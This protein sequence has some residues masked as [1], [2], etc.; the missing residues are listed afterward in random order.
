MRKVR[1]GRVENRDEAGVCRKVRFETRAKARKKLRGP[2]VGQSSV[3][4]VYFCRQCL[5]WHLSS[6]RWDEPAK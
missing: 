2:V 1:G 6:R 5:A 4:D 3:K